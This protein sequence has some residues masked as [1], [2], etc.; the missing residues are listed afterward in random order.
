MLQTN[1]LKRFT[2]PEVLAHPW[3]SRDTPTYLRDIYDQQPLA[4]STID[5]LSSLVLSTKDPSASASASALSSSSSSSSNDDDGH[6]EFYPGIGKLDP[7]VFNDLQAA[8]GVDPSIVSSALAAFEDNCVK[9]A[10]QLFADRKG[11]RSCKVYWFIYFLLLCFFFF[12]F[13]SSLGM[14]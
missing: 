12:F 13:F 11:D 4:P 7:K 5:S 2:I 1:P 10:Y 8:L 14:R 6:P 9:V 3:V